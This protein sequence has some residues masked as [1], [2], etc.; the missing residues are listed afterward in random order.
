V[1]LS[2]KDPAKA[3]ELARTAIPNINDYIRDVPAFRK[4]KRQLVE[5]F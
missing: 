1:A 3:K 2:G 5:A 4:V